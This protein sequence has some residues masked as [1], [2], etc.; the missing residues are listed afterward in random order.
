M[1]ETLV[2]FRP[3]RLQGHACLQSVRPARPPAHLAVD[4]L[5]QIDEW[6]LHSRSLSQP[7]ACGNGKNSNSPDRSQKQKAR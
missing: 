7:A 2:Q 5:P 4:L 1:F 3:E 6:L